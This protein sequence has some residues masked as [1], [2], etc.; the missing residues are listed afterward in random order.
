M[1]CTAM[2][3]LPLVAIML[4]SSCRKEKINI[5]KNLDIE[6][7]QRFSVPQYRLNARHIRNY[8]QR[9]TRNDR[10]SMLPDRYTKRY[11]LDKKDFLWIN[12]CGIDAAQIRSLVD[13][14]LIHI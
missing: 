13:L 14:S 8:L 7:Y 9:L 10:D 2:V 6:A 1:S 11:Y 5:N 4:L 3:M 12:R